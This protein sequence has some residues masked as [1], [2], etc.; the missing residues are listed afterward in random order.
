MRFPSTGLDSFE[1]F[2]RFRESRADYLDDCYRREQS[3]ATVAP[4]VT[5]TGTCALCLQV[6]QFVSHTAGGERTVDG[7]AVPNWREQQSCGCDDRLNSRERAVLQYAL[8]QYALPALGSPAWYRT[9]LLGPA[10]GLFR[11]LTRLGAAPVLWP[12]LNAGHA[13]SA[14]ALPA[15]DAGVSLVLCSD[16][17]HCVPQLDAAL[18]ELAR[19]LAPGG[20]LLFTV[21]FH[22]N[23]RDTLSDLTRVPR[24]NGRMPTLMAEPVHQIGWNILDRLSAAGFEDCLAHCYWSEELG[25][26]GPANMLF[27]ASR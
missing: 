9:A 12:R 13:A 15:K 26:L 6:T 27:A 22:A 1:A 10:P 5:V 4:S 8:A 23:S 3:L 25:Y 21:P 20:L 18:A 7:R 11:R 16:H 19:V 14:V 17:L 24:R 2:R